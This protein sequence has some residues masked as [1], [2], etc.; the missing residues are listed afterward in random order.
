MVICFLLNI[1]GLTFKNKKYNKGYSLWQLKVSRL[2]NNIWKTKV[3]PNEIIPIHWRSV[4]RFFLN[5]LSC[6]IHSCIL[7][8]MHE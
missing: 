3:N 6:N 5:V 7:D 1:G 2:L 4:K 8:G